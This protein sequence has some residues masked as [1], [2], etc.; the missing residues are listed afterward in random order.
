MENPRRNSLMFYIR[1]QMKRTKKYVSP[2]IKDHHVQDAGNHGNN[3]S[4]MTD[5]LMKH[6]YKR[7]VTVTVKSNYFFVQF[8]V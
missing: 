7:H 3:L 6:V 1:M 5:M 8:H 2:R 4:S